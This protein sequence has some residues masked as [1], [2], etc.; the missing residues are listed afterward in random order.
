[1]EPRSGRYV[2]PDGSIFLQAS[3]RVGFL[4]TDGVYVTIEAPTED[5]ILETARALEPM[6]G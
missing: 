2:P 1:M 4:K 3:G 6:P 5:L